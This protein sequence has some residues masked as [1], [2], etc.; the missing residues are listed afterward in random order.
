MKRPPGILLGAGTLIHRGRRLLV[1]KR[2]EEPNL[3]AWTFPGGRVEPGETPEEAAVREAKE[4]VGLGVELE[5][6]FSVVTYK[7]GEL[8]AGS[9]PQM[10]I[11]EY[12]ARPKRGRVKLN[13]ESSAFKWVTP[14]ELLRM[15]TTR[16][17]KECARKFALTKPR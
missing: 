14:A 15:R 10:V 2:A 17:M 16:Q 7:S 6:L 12:L 11:V 8:G 9:R 13:G 3:G 4:E 5:G 1:V